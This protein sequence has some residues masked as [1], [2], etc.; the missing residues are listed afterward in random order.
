LNT[1]LPARIDPRSFFFSSA[2][3]VWVK[4]RE[5]RFQTKHVRFPAMPN[6]GAVNENLF[7]AAGKYLRFNDK[8]DYPWRRSA[9]II[10]I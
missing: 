9:A 3:V 2:I 1:D 5:T 4:A 10:I 8:I 6:D 7:V